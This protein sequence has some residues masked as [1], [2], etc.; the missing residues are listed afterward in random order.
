MPPPLRG[1][2]DG[3]S[4]EQARDGRSRGH[5]C[6]DGSRGARSR[7]WIPEVR[8]AARWERLR[9]RILRARTRRRPHEVRT[10]AMWQRPRRRIPWGSSVTASP[11]GARGSDPLRCA[12]RWRGSGCGGGS[13][14]HVSNDDTPKACMTTRWERLVQRILGFMRVRVD[15]WARMTVMP[16]KVGAAMADFSRRKRRRHPPLGTKWWCIP[17]AR[18]WFRRAAILFL[19][20]FVYIFM[21]MSIGFYDLYFSSWLRFHLFVCLWYFYSYFT[22]RIYWFYTLSRLLNPVCIGFLPFMSYV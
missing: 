20:Y 19:C 18:R 15:P 5:A 6:D 9:H 22:Q 21:P 7:R 10:T 4:W 13:R 3:E 17:D 8:T 12:R 16:S 14:G 1:A 2:R 11:W